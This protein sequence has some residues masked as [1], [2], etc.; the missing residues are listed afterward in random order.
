MSS[1]T[2]SRK[3][4]ASGRRGA[5]RRP[6]R[7]AFVWVFQKPAQ[8]WPLFRLGSPSRPSLA[9][10]LPQLRHHLADAPFRPFAERDTM[11]DQFSILR[12]DG[13][14]VRNVPVGNGACRTPCPARDKPR[15]FGDP[16]F[17]APCA[18]RNR[19]RAGPYF[20]SCR[21]PARRATGEPGFWETRFF[22]R[23][24]CGPTRT[25]WADAI[26]DHSV[27]QGKLIAADPQGTATAPEKED[28][29]RRPT[30]PARGF[31]LR[32]DHSGR[33]RWDTASCARGRPQTPDRGDGPC[34]P[35]ARTAGP[36]PARQR[37]AITR[38]HGVRPSL[39]RHAGGLPSSIS[40]GP[41]PSRLHPQRRRV[42]V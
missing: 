25:A 21:R 14:E 36:A 39:C 32:S 23:A 1:A 24:H 17:P 29:R 6:A 27:K 28:R 19:V 4:C 2:A 5:C 11:A 33:G 37:L 34:L 31:S 22:W 18:R 13:A 20:L 41:L 38:Q 26:D 40:A 9:S 30:G 7:R 42:P 15:G 12:R 35:R 10:A 8:S 3:P 16:R